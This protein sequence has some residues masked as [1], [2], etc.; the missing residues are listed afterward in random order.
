[1]RDWAAWHREYDLPDSSLAT[2]LALVQVHVADALTTSPP[3]PIRLVSLCAGEGRDV[4][5]VL[6]SHA[7]R[8]DVTAILVELDA[9]N[10]AT[11]RERAA[12]AGLTAAVEVR[13]A[14]AGLVAVFA[15]ALPAD[16]LLLCGI[17]GNVADSDIQRTATA[18]ALLCRPGGTVIWTRHRREPDLTPR[19]RSWFA[20]AGFEEVAFER[21]PTER[22]TS[23]GV[24]RLRSAAPDAR[25]PAERLFTFQAR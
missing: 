7:R 23:V 9:R 21:P 24:H 4:L 5:G 2:R 3:G 13:Q 16:V 19:L 6:P 22:L 14:D 10:A 11:A 8:V 20:D 25:L 1:M 18:A 17:F 15:D 12:E